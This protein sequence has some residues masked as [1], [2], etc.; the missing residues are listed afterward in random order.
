MYVGTKE[1]KLIKYQ[2]KGSKIPKKIHF[3]SFFFTKKLKTIIIFAFF[4]QK[5]SKI[6]LDWAVLSEWVLGSGVLSIDLHDNDLI[7]ETND[8]RVMLINIAD[9]AK[10]A[11]PQMILRSHAGGDA[12]VWGLA[13][14]PNSA[15]AV[16]GGDDK[17]IIVW[18]MDTKMA[19]ASMKFKTEQIRSVA[20]SPDKN[21][22]AV[23]SAQGNFFVFGLKQLHKVCFLVFFF[24]CR[25][26]QYLT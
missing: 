5:H 2:I 3:F 15:L 11:A 24:I 18:N 22:V 4:H 10:K 12:E 9:A 23:G 21:E 1:G 6:C 20:V 25:N 16:S 26:L 7:A 8:G 19:E 14:V 13:T 17:R